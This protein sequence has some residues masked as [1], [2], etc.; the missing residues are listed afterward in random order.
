MPVE[1]SVIIPTFNEKANLPAL[2]ER[3]EIALD[4]VAWE[5]IIVDDDSPDGTHRMVKTLASTNPRFRCIRRVNRRGLAGACIEGVLGS[6]APFVAVMDAD[7]QHDETIL[8]SMLQRLRSGDIDLVVGSRYV[9]RGMASSGFSQWRNASSLLARTAAQWTLRVNFRDLMSGFFMIRREVVENIAPDLSTAGFKVLLDIAATSGPNLRIEE[10]G[11]V[12]RKRT[13]GESKLDARVAFDF[14]GLVLSKKSKG[15]LPTRFVS[16]ASVG[17]SGVAIHLAA[18]YLLR[19]IMTLEFV[20]AQALAT[21]LA[22]TSNFFINNAITYKDLRLRREA[23]L[24]GLLRFYLVCSAGALANIGV[25]TLI[26]EHI[27]NWLLASVTGIAM[28]SVW[29]Y[30]LSSLY[31]W[32]DRR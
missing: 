18:L 8:P 5:V 20:Y 1:L 24:S 13:R 12:F 17:L 26:Y 2:F 27:P 6:S 21:W 32:N 4:G 15:L 31:V 30:A 14:L 10:I 9:D 16:F 29:N 19:S 25:A 7:L 23:I 22:M 3:L 28:G 11:Y